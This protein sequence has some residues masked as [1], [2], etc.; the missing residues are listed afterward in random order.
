MTDNGPPRYPGE[1]DEPLDY[2]EG[3][4]LPPPVYPVPHPGLPGSGYHSPYP[5]FAAYQR[6][7]PPPGTNRKAIVAL[8]CA[9]AGVACCLPSLVGLVLGLIA[10]NETRRTGQDG[11]S[12]AGAAVLISALV[13]VGY[14]A[15]VVVFAV[16]SGPSAG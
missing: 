8:V 6:P 9:V 15:Y 3:A 5:D 12:L 11:H 16:V 14:A 7:A 2:P 1:S 13:I 10:R 4:G